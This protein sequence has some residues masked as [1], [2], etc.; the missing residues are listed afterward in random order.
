MD[1]PLLPCVQNVIIGFTQDTGRTLVRD[2]DF[3]S[4]LV[5]GEWHGPDGYKVQLL[6][7]AEYVLSKNY[8]KCLDTCKVYAVSYI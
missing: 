1:L 5:Y 4:W 2:N 7:E 8:N 6:Q 3:I